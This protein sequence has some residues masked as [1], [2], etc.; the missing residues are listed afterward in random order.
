MATDT[1]VAPPTATTRRTGRWIEEW[2]PE[3]DRFW[4]SSGRGIARRNLVLSIGVEFLGFAI[5]QIMS[6]VVVSMTPANGWSYTTSE[7]FWLVALPSLVGATLRF[8]YTF[9]PGRLGG[10]NFTIVS[11]LLLLVPAVGLTVTLSNPDTP[12]GV[13]L[14]V[15][16]LTGFGGGNFASSMSNISFFYPE[17]EKGF[18]LGL[19]AAGGNLGVAVVQFAIPLIVV[20]G[21]GVTLDRAGYIWIPLAVLAAVLAWRLMDNLGQAKADL[22]S[23]LAAAR[24]GHTWVLSL[25]YVG[26]FGSFIG[27]GASFPLVLQTTFGGSG[28]LAFVG[29]LVG[30][31]SRPLGGRLADRF[32]GARVTVAMFA[33]MAIAAASVAQFIPSRNYAGFV[34]CFL[35]LFVASGMGNG[36]TYR[37]IPAIFAGRA[38]AAGGPGALLAGKK[39]A[40]A[41]IG[42]CSAVGAYGGFLISQGFRISREQTGGLAPAL[43]LF[44]A[45]YVLALVV[46]AAVYLRRRDSVVAGV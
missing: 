40:A 45:F 6:I 42:I 5:W 7:K 22:A 8:P 44:V 31:L 9:G 25:L 3:D 37:M 30:S 15:A 29:A 4:A 33:V 21:A 14:L 34:L 39:Q 32:G 24:F 20:I 10:R 41:A 13:M 38:R 27:Y 12:F 17:R 1:R 23:S 46:T 36:S 35:V 11:A 43:Y 18:A 19:N 26:T 16:G 28:R 2:D